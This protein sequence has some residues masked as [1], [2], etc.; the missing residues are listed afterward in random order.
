MIRVKRLNDHVSGAL[1]FLEGFIEEEKVVFVG[2]VVG[3]IESDICIEKDDEVEGESVD[4]LGE[5]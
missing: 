1:M 3:D 5:E 4:R 2:V